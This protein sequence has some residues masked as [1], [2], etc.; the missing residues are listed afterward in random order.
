[1][2]R[3]PLPSDFRAAEHD[4]R[5]DW[6]IGGPWRLAVAREVRGAEQLPATAPERVRPAELDAKGLADA[7]N[8]ADCWAVAGAIV[9]GRVSDLDRRARLDEFTSGAVLLRR[10]L[11]RRDVFCFVRRHPAATRVD[12]LP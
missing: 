1:M 2:V 11:A 9:M 5:Q 12:T 4:D 3:A 7:K 6:K 8:Y 10:L